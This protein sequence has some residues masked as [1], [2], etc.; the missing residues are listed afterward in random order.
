MIDLHAFRRRY[1]QRALT[2][3]EPLEIGTADELAIIVDEGTDLLRLACRD[4]GISL[5]D[6]QAN[7]V[8]LLIS[9]RI[10]DRLTHVFVSGSTETV[11]FEML[12]A[13]R[14]AGPGLAIEPDLEARLP[15]I[16]LA[17]SIAAMADGGRLVVKSVSLG[18][19]GV[20]GGLFT[21]YR[22]GWTII[23][24]AG[25]PDEVLAEVF[26]HELGHALDMVVNGSAVTD[27][28]GREALA[29]ALTVPLLEHRPATVAEAR[30]LV[31]AATAECAPYRHSAPESNSLDDVLT[32]ALE[33]VGAILP[34]PEMIAAFTQP[35]QE[36]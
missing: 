27:Y 10:K 33:E 35:K 34:Q 11:S 3:R 7:D 12:M 6:D 28:E 17:R 2:R 31:E 18:S 24:D 19:M 8:Q 36:P 30:P 1:I 16:P 32:W 25:L 5:D 13:T 23:V 26:A 9:E 21:M 14:E 29:D 15:L 4:A 22:S 20:F